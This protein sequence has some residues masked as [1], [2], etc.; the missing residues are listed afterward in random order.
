MLSRYRTSIESDLPLTTASIASLIIGSSYVGD[1]Y[2]KFQEVFKQV[3][4]YF[5]HNGFRMKL[6]SL[7]GMAFVPNAHDDTVVCPGCHFQVI[8]KVFL[9][10]CKGVITYGLERIGEALENTFAVVMNE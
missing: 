1:G 3:M 7:N 6:Y 10:N 2:L 5:G 4:A 9:V 8:R